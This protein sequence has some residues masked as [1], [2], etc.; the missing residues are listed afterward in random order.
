[1]AIAGFSPDAL[2]WAAA[3][4]DAAQRSPLLHGIYQRWHDA[5]P[6]KAAEFLTTAPP[7]LAVELS[8]LP[9]AP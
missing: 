1:M 9:K 4:P 5:E 7:D 8:V 3:V 6:V 2:K